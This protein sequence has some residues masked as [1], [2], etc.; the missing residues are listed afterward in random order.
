MYIA[1]L[2]D[3]IADRKQ[4]ERLLG[5][6]NDALSAK[7]G[8]LYI[9]AYGDADSLMGAPMKYGLFFI[10]ITSNED[11]GRSVVERLKTLGVPGRITICQPEDTPFSYSDAINGLF[12]IQK[13]IAAAPLHKMILD[14]Y[15]AQLQASVP[16][17]EIRGESETHYVPLEKIIY[18]Q[19]RSHLVY[20]YL[21]DG[22]VLSMLGEIGDFYRWVDGHQEF[23]F[24]KKDT[25]IN[26]NHVLSKSKKEYHL[27]GGIKIVVSRFGDFLKF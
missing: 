10:D 20:V 26:Q 16:T 4:L 15:N 19:S 23:F 27:T 11:H 17:I 5:R 9:D 13:P 12:S 1:V 6:A 21:E 8:T 14:A 22:S 18:A 2:A 7:T 24:A 3:N 25:V